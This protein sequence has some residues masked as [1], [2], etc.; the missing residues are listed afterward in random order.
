M[1]RKTGQLISRGSRTWLVR[2]S[3]GRDPETGTAN[4]TKKTI[5]GSFRE[6]Q[7]YLRNIALLPD[8]TPADEFAVL[9]HEIARELLHRGE[10]RTQTTKVVRETEAEAV[11]FVVCQSIGLACGTSASDY[12]QLYTGERETLAASLAFIQQT[13][14]EIIATLHHSAVPPPD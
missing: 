9:S 7:T 5:R 10:R 11:A 12:I 3:L 4:T 13:A 2:V 1:A 8:M 6:A 14:C